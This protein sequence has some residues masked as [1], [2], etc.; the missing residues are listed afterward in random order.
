M[1]IA[2]RPPGILPGSARL[3]PGAASRPGWQAPGA[4]PRGGVLRWSAGVEA[5]RSLARAAAAHVAAAPGVP[6]HHHPRSCG[7]VPI[8]RPASGTPAIGT[9][10]GRHQL[11]SARWCAW[12]RWPGCA[13]GW[14]STPAS[15]S[16]AS[17]AVG[18]PPW[19]KGQLTGAVAGRYP[20]PR[21]RG[22]QA[23]LQACWSSISAARVIPR[24][25]AAWTG[26]TRSTPAPWAQRAAA[27]ERPPTA[28]GGLRGGEVPPP[29]A[30]P[31]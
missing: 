18:N 12:T 6:G 11:V 15:S 31:C 13:P 21:P 30:C 17:R 14:W 28:A 7:A 29:A 3:G 8:P 9:P 26:S 5:G 23:G 27:D 22:H 25:P 20:G 24:R 16:S 10:V 1:D 2:A 19:S 4:G